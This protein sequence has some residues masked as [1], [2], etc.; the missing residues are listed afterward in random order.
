[1]KNLTSVVKS[2]HKRAI[3]VQPEQ[4]PTVVNVDLSFGL[5]AESLH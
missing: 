3:V 2:E 1:M 4:M 5:C